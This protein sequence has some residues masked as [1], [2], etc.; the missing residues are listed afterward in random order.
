MEELTIEIT[1]IGLIIIN[2]LWMG[3][4]ILRSRREKK[5]RERLFAWLDE[6]PDFWGVDKELWDAEIKKKKW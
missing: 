1:L 6:I 5:K 2:L 3:G 4:Q